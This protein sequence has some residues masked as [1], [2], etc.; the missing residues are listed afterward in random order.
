MNFETNFF[1]HTTVSSVNTIAADSLHLLIP[2][3][4]FD[5][6]LMCPNLLDPDRI[7][8][9]LGDGSTASLINKTNTNLYTGMYVAKIKILRKQCIYRTNG[10]DAYKNRRSGNERRR[11]SLYL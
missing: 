7:S 3:Y 2:G 8:I 10:N 9:L 1:T 11:V 5:S 6:R 4:H